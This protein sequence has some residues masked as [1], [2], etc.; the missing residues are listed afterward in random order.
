MSL[1]QSKCK[2]E[3]KS[4]GDILVRPD[5]SSGEHDFQTDPSKYPLTMP[6]PKFDSRKQTAGEA[7]FIGD[8]PAMKGQ[9]HA[10]FFKA[11]VGSGEVKS[12]DT[13]KAEA[14]PGVVKWVH[15]GISQIL[16]TSP[17]AEEFIVFCY[18]SARN[19]WH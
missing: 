9:L 10:V 6:T 11:T 19:V 13:S 4:G 17:T 16:H 3:A 7:Q 14:A 1:S 2:P 12:I 5:R 8:I 18:I 15:F